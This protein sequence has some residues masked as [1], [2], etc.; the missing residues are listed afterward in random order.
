MCASK[1][2]Y[3]VE[4]DEIRDDLA[5]KARGWTVDE[6]K[7]CLAGT[8]MHWV[9]SIRTLEAEGERGGMY[10]VPVE[11]FQA[12]DAAFRDV[13]WALAAELMRREDEHDRT[14]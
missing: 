6:L 10:V 14:R 9:E 12:C 3:S 5:D 7:T 2:R 13:A 11:S 4:A 1:R 8:A